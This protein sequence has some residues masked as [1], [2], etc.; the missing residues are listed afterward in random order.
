MARGGKLDG[1]PSASVCG[2][3]VRFGL[4]RDIY[5]AENNLKEAMHGEGVV[6]RIERYH[7]DG[8]ANTDRS[9]PGVATRLSEI[10][11]ILGSARTPFG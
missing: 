5:V 7:E 8:R 10:I 6:G 1:H 4:T 11:A 2:A 9:G 3:D